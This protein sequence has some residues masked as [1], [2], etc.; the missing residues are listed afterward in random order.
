MNKSLTT[1]GEHK[2]GWNLGSESLP[3]PVRSLSVNATHILPSFR[4]K[5]LQSFSS[6]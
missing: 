5:T 6:C 3:L 2:R 4:A 1:F